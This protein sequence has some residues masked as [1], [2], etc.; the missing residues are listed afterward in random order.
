MA[1]M[2]F[3]SEHKPFTGASNPLSRAADRGELSAVSPSRISFA[4]T[5][6][7]T[8]PETSIWRNKLACTAIHTRGP[9]LLS[10][11]NLISLCQ[12]EL[13]AS[14]LSYADLVGAASRRKVRSLYG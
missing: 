4:K 8:K 1:S 6:A 12:T 7:T 2:Q 13:V 10:E 5:R 11:L 14:A 9:D 3:I